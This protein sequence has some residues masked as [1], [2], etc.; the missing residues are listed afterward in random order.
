MIT[1]GKGGSN[2]LTG[3][4]FEGKVDLNT[5]LNQ[6][7]GYKVEG[8]HVFYLEEEVGQ[9]FKKSRALFRVLEATRN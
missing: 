7:P 5:F 6:Q 3:L 9:I 2:T 1:G 8:S 4:I